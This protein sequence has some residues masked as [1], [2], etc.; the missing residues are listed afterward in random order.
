MIGRLTKNQERQ[1]AISILGL[2]VVLLLVLVIA[3]VWSAN[4]NYD[5]QIDR[6]QTRLQILK[7]RA[8]VDA[9]L[10]PRYEQLVSSHAASGH[11]LKGD[12][13]A[14]TAAELQGIVNRITSSNAAQILSMQILPT[15]EEQ[16]FIRV[17][18]RVRVRGPLEGIVQSIYDIEA[19]PTFLFIDNL[20]LRDGA[21]RR[22]RSTTEINQFDGD[23]DLI[24]YMPKPL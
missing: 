18:L 24:A 19:N 13:E 21:R 22:L 2:V 14:V 17:T 4:A 12:T 15:A 6:L 16:G 9:T 20:S 10:R 5:S 3:P 7:S 8:A 1:L 23:F 11:H